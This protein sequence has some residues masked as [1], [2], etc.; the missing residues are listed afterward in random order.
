MR[1]LLSRTTLLPHTVGDWIVSILSILVLVAVILVIRSHKKDLKE[2]KDDLESKLLEMS[3]K[4][5][6]AQE[7]PAEQA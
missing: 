3:H 4:E 5:G 7:A 6:E 2:Q 1:Y